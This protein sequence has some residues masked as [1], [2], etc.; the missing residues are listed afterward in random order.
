VADE[1]LR[2]VR[3]RIAGEVREAA[4]SL[5]AQQAEATQADASVGLLSALADEVER[6]V[7]AGDLARADALAA[8]AEWLA[9]KTLQSEAQQRLLTARTRLTLLTGLDAPVLAE[10]A[11]ASSASVKDALAS[12]P[13]LRLAQAAAEHARRR[14][15]VL[16]VSRRE[17]PEL[18]V[19]V[20]QEVAGNGQSGQYSAIVGL[21]LPLGTTDRNRPLL[22]AAMADLDVAQASEERLRERL[23]AELTSAQ[24][25]LQQADRQLE[26]ERS[27]AALLRERAQLIDKS[28]RAGE[29]ALSDLLRALAAATQ[30]DAA[31]ARQHAALGLSRARLNQAIGVLP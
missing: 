5:A 11:A 6:R 17:A 20:R 22:A 3:L 24:A 2:A 26:A 12:H 10:E 13:E 15:A 28:F 8:R 29:S 30:A 7:R 27:R 23:A 19:G 21:R 9:T 18:T 16:D 4:W 14:L 1:T 25:G 31:M